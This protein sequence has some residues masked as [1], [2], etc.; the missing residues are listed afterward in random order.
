MTDNAIYL[1]GLNCGLKDPPL[2]SEKC[3]P[4]LAAADFCDQDS[5]EVL[6]DMM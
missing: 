6:V 2:R 1:A 5:F 4:E 3:F